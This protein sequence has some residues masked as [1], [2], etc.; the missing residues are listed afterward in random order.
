MKKKNVDEELLEGIEALARNLALEIRYEKG[1]FH[2]GLCRLEDQ[3]TFII[4]K[5]L[6]TSE[7]IKV[8]ARELANMDLEGIY[9]LPAIRERIE[10]E[11]LTQ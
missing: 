5:D 9:I 6:S 10:D 1:N 7:K 2:G 3:R 11:K 8:F 4:N